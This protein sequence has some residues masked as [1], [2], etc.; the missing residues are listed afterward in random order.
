MPSAGAV[1]AAIRRKV[2][3]F[4]SPV[5][6][7]LW[8]VPDQSI[9]VL[10]EQGPQKGNALRYGAH[11]ALDG[12]TTHALEHGPETAMHEHT[13]RTGKRL[14]EWD[15]RP[16]SRC[17]GTSSALPAGTRYFSPVGER[18]DRD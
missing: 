6:S 12:I 8:L 13:R 7:R 16:S 9:S 4:I 2:L 17:Q 3:R 10:S 1:M 14:A 15:Q 5:I 11:H 18:G